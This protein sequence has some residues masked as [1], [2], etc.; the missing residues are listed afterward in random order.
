VSAL[1]TAIA[2]TS[3]PVAAKTEFFLVIEMWDG[4]NA[5][6]KLADELMPDLTSCWSRAQ[7]AVDRA[8]KVEGEFELL[9]YCS[10]RKTM[11]DPV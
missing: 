1:V 10:V 4:K 5:P 11:D 8:T 6:M 9:A 7:E 2:G 3:E